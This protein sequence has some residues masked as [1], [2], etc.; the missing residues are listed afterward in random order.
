MVTQR[1]LRAGRAY[2]W[3]LPNSRSQEYVQAPQNRVKFTT[4]REKYGEKEWLEMTPDR[5][6]RS[7]PPCN[8]F[9]PLQAHAP[10]RSRSQESNMNGDSNSTDPSS[11]PSAEIQPFHQT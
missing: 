9:S 2:N 6:D 5:P 10:G 4:K 3:E 11:C 8:R 1:C 7:D